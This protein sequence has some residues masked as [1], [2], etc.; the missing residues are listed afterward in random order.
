MVAS[1]P[2]VVAVNV[3]RRDQSVARSWLRVSTSVARLCENARSDSRKSSLQ[4]IGLSDPAPRRHVTN[5][6]VVFRQHPLDAASPDLRACS[7]MSHNL[8]RRPGIRLWLAV[9]LPVAERASEARYL[10]RRRRQHRQHRL[11]LRRRRAGAT[12][13]TRSPKITMTKPITTPRPAPRTAVGSAVANCALV[14]VVNDSIVAGTMTMG[15]VSAT[16]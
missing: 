13:H 9:K 12:H 4:V 8:V 14:P 2:G 1:R 16:A 6:R 3:A 11:N 10:P 7:Q 5:R 15:P